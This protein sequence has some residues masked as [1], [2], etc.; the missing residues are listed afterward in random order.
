[1]N[2]CSQINAEKPADADAADEDAVD[3]DADDEDAIVCCC[4]F[5]GCCVMQKT[6]QCCL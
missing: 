1:M 3:E 4:R 6:Y 2:H 5:L